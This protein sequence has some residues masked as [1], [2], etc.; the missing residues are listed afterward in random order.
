MAILT[1]SDAYTNR[2]E[3]MIKRGVENFYKSH[4][5]YDIKVE[6]IDFNFTDDRKKVTVNVHLK[7]GKLYEIN[8]LI[9]ADQKIADRFKIGH[10]LKAYSGHNSYSAHDVNDIVAEIKSSLSNHGY[11]MATVSPGYKLDK[12]NNK[13]TV[14]L[15]IELGSKSIVREIDFVGNAKTNSIV[16]RKKC[17]AVRRSAIINDKSQ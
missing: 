16:L 8:K 9:F 12:K 3:D 5:F 7:E 10:I 17:F 4:G 15:L 13:V 14:R 1:D 11:A 2:S 6:K